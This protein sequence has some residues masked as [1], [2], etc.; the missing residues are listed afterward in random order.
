LAE[1]TEIVPVIAPV[2][3]F[4]VRPAGSEPLEMAK[5]N[6]GIPP[7]VE[8]IVETVPTAIPGN[9]VETIF[10]LDAGFAVMVPEYCFD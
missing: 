2:D 4:K 9:A 10:T 8:I 1:T 7:E 5:V 6:G 3:V